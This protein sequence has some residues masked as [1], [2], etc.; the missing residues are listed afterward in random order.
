MPNQPFRFLDSPPAV[1]RLRR[2]LARAGLS[3][4]LEPGVTAADPYLPACL[5][6]TCRWLRDPVELQWHYSWW[7][8]GSNSELSRVAV[9]YQGMVVGEVAVEE[10]RGEGL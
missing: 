9:V 7:P 2:V 4:T 8:D 6:F 10:L 1:A 5:A 3:G